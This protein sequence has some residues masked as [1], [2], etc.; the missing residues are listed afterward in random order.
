MKRYYRTN[1][2]AEKIGVS[3]QYISRLIKAGRI[4]GI[5]QIAGWHIFTDDDI[6]KIKKEIKYKFKKVK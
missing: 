3:R 2:V 6:K 4:K 1:E 5:K